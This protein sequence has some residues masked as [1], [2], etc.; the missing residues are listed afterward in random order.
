VEKQAGNKS[1]EQHMNFLGNARIGTRLGIAFALIVAIM[2]ALVVVAKIGL[3]SVKADVDLINKDLFPKV[4]MTGEVKQLVNEQA[5]AARNALLLESAADR[6]RELRGIE[7]DRTRIGEIYKTLEPMLQSEKGKALFAELQAER[8]DFSRE[9]DPFL[10]LVRAGN[11]AGARAQLFDRLRPQ[12]LDYMKALD[13]FSDFQEQLMA[14]EGEQTYRDIN[15]TELVMILATLVGAGLAAF[16][17]FVATRSV[18]RP[19]NEAVGALNRVADGDLT[20][21][22]DTHRG[23]EVGDL[24]KSLQATVG[25]LRTVVGQV[26]TGVDSVSTASGEIAAGNQDLSSRTEQQASSLQQTAASMEELTSTVRQSADNARQANQLASAASEAAGKGGQVVGQ[27]VATMNDITASSK[28]I[29]DIIS[30]IDGIAFQTNILAL[31]AAVEAARAGEQGRGFAVVAGEVRNLAQRSAQ[32]AR[33]I[34]SL[35]GES[36]EK[37]EAGS[38]QVN[39]AG[40]AMSEIVSQVKRVTDLIGEISSAAGEQS[41][42]IGQVNDAVTQMDQVTQQNAA[43]VE[44]SA[45][46]AASL[47][48]QAERLL[49]AVSV[50]KVAQGETR[51]VI[52]QAQAR[53]RSSVK[54]KTAVPAAKAKAAIDKRAVDKPMGVAKSDDWQEF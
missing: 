40:S 34:K 27:V 6:E 49:Q 38:R 2:V 18:V 33:E 20:V 21:E 16:F 19:L 51:S 30:V 25:A 31:N 53:S 35:I 26:R 41:S 32:A 1:T 39:D 14:D 12:Q 8:S 17:A 44:Q 45:A 23:D 10:Q 50:F 36:V 46:A 29:A 4:K 47:R 11:T 28:K 22:V 7:E 43:L 13:G 54:A 42:G 52:A 3:V 15:R 5:R 37:V 24:L 9:M 48:D